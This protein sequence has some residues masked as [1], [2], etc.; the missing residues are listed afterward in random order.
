M[1]RNWHSGSIAVALLAVLLLAGAMLLG[2]QIVRRSQHLTNLEPIPSGSNAAVR[3]M[4]AVFL[5]VLEN[6]S[7]GDIIGSPDAPY[8]NELIDRFGL[9]TDYQAIAH[10]SQPNYLAMFS[11]S[12]HDVLDDEVSDVAAPNLGDQL[13]S[14]GQTWRVYAENVPTGGCFTGATANGGPDG[15]GTYVRKHNPAISF[16]TISGSPE[17]CA[18]IQPFAAFDPGAADFELIVPNMC[19]IMHDCPVSSGDAWLRRFVPEILDSPAWR[20][21]GV[22]FITFDEG[23]ESS[24]RNEVPML[25]IASD[26]PAGFRSAIAHN[27]YSLLR[28][29]ELGLGLDCLAESCSANTMGEF[30]TTSPD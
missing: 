26:V 23:A 12:T 13:E 7:E 19:H 18:N 15:D 2:S 27:H 20:D 4:S 10:P 24:S 17:R 5:I 30:F 1:A 11:G 28:T 14:D 21:G 8:L 3:P 6:K 9:A 29:I 25:V 16:T 22:L